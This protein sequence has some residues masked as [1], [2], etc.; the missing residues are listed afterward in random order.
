MCFGDLPGDGI[1][2]S[3]P[4]PIVNN[5]DHEQDWQPYPVDPYSA[6]CD[7]HTYIPVYMYW[8]STAVCIGLYTR[9]QYI[10]YLGTCTFVHGSLLLYNIHMLACDS[11]TVSSTW[12]LTSVSMRY[13]QGDGINTSLSRLVYCTH[14]YNIT[15]SSVVS[16]LVFMGI[17]RGT[18][19]C[20]LGR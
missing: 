2:V 15:L 1:V 19:M 12:E 5:S 18:V 7:D 11:I 20:C 17:F 16:C 6:R 14:V 13:S 3:P 4:S 9:Y 10:F 8:Y